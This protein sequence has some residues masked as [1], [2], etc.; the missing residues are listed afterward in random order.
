[1]QYLSLISSIVL[2]FT[3]HIIGALQKSPED[4]QDALL[5]RDELARLF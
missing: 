3:P 2:S 1:M 5:H 4:A